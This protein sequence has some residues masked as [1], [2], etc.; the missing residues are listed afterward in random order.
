MSS[1]STDDPPDT[2]S[3]VVVRRRIVVRGRV[4]GVGYRLSC[5]RRA[6][7]AGVAGWVRN[8]VDG[9]VEL[10]A[11]GPADAVAGLLTWC[12]TGPPAARVTAVEVVE[13]DPAGLVGFDI[14]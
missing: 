9:S 14:R 4:H 6:E 8:C 12:R 11:E 10:D 3:D 5:V 13:E 2:P 1:G 7:A